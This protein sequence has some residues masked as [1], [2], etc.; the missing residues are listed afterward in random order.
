[1]IYV[2]AVISV[3]VPKKLKDEAEKLGI[4]IKETVRKSII[5]AI[6]EEK[7]RRIAESLVEL[8]KNMEGLSEEDWVKAIRESRDEGR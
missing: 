2:S 6:E 5:Q 1:V 3:R 8:A 4:D 7:A